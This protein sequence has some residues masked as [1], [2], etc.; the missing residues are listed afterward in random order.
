MENTA[1]KY[2]GAPL[3]EKPLQ[4][5]GIKLCDD[6]EI[7]ELLF[8]S[9]FMPCCAQLALPYWAK[10]TGTLTNASPEEKTLRIMAILLDGQDQILGEYSD[11]LILDENESG[12]FEIKLT[13]F[14]NETKGYSLYIEH[15]E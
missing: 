12:V 6:V 13:Q 10:I 15:I 4:P 11:M 2:C 3:V 8:L 1:T 9:S 5:S 14:Q 7:V